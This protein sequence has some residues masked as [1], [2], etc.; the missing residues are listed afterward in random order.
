M[1]Q[2]V[3]P[4]HLIIATAWENKPGENRTLVADQYRKY[5]VFL[6]EDGSLCF[7]AKAAEFITI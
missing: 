4:R 6:L 1:E 3:S 5:G 2:E 7:G